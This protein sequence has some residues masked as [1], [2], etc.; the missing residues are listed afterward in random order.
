VEQILADII[1]FLRAVGPEVVFFVTLVETAFFIGLL[2]PAEATVLV[3]AFLVSD[4]VFSLEP[5]LAATIGG[6]FV[7]DQIGYA[8]GRYGG[9]RFAARGGRIGRLWARSEPKAMSMFGGHPIVAVSLARFVSFVRTVMPWFAG[10][11]H[12][13]YGRFAFFDAIGV[14][15]WGVASVLAGYLAGESWHV[16]AGALGT[17]SAII[18]G[19]LLLILIVLAIRSRRAARI[20]TNPTETPGPDPVAPETAD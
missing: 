15:G 10:M 11:S 4:G 5:V 20:V 12:M 13:P 16:L 14:I 17:A 8:L 18:V 2:V 6:A 7:G 9:R 1:G 19:I 3:A